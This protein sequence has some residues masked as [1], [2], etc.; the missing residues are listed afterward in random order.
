MTS[1]GELFEVL[2]A[3]FTE[4]AEMTEH[5]ETIATGCRFTEGP[6]YFPP[7]Q[8][9]D[10]PE[11]F[12]A[13][14]LIREKILHETRQEVPH[15]IAVFIDQCL[16]RINR[17]YLTVVDDSDAVADGFRL[18]HGMRSEQDAVSFF[19]HGFY[20]LPELPP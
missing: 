11:R 13:A 14:E 9:T 10:Q 15:S 7:D 2:D 17:Y 4:C 12:L 1:S 20:T 5:L 6:V 16:R 8:V 19:A 3:R 18:F